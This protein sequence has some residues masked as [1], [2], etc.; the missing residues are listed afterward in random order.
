MGGDRGWG[1]GSPSGEGERLTPRRTEREAN[2]GRAS[3]TYLP[4][5]FVTF[6]IIFFGLFSNPAT[7]S[8]QQK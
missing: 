3:Q 1:K 6:A 4:S 8:S 2:G 5:F 7:Q